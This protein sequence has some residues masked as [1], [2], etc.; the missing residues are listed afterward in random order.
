[1][2][3]VKDDPQDDVDRLFARMRPLTPPPNIIGTAIAEAEA[4]HA[5]RVLRLAIPGYA[6]VLI[7]IGVISFAFGRALAA[8]GV[9]DVVALALLDPTTI[10]DA[11]LD[12]TLAVA[13][14]VSWGLLT[15]LAVACVVLGWCSRFVSA[16]GRGLRT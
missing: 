5:L 15:A 1:M 2:S 11:P 10:T 12:F 6:V 16:A 9:G 3:I 13:E 7:A 14:N 4:R 8:S